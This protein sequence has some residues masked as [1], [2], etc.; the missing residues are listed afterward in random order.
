MVGTLTCQAANAAMKVMGSRRAPVPHGWE[1]PLTLTIA[2]H[3]LKRE[4]W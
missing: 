3:L 1:K 4:T 2:G